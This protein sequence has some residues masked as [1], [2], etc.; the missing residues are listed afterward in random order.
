MQNASKYLQFWAKVSPDSL[1][2]ADERY[3]FTFLELDSIVRKT[4]TYL[5]NFGVKAG[6]LVA[7][8]LNSVFNYIFSITLNSMGV[9]SIVRSNKNLL[10][11]ELEPDFYISTSQPE[12][13]PPQRTVIF[14]EALVKSINKSDE[15]VTFAGFRSEDIPVVVWSTSGTTGKEKFIELNAKKL[16]E[17][18]VEPT[19]TNFF[20]N[21]HVL[22]LL[23]FGAFWSSKVAFQALLFGK[24][25]L[26]FGYPDERILEIISRF[27][28]K[29]VMGSTSQLARL[30]DDVESH[31]SDNRKVSEISTF[32]IGGEAPSIKLVERL[33]KHFDCRIF[34]NYG[35]SEVG[36]I[37]HCEVKDGT[38]PMIIRPFVDLEI[39]DSEDRVL[40]YG[41][42]GYI[43]VRSNSLPD[44]YL[45]S[46][47]DSQKALRNGF[48]YSGDL[49]L[50]DRNGNLVLSGRSANILNISGSKIHPESLEAHIA[51]IVGVSQSVALPWLNEARGVE[52]LAFA[53]V[54][55]PDFDQHLL[56]IWL[57]STFGSLGAVNIFLTGELAMNSAGKIVREEMA[58]R[59][60]GAK[61]DLRVVTSPGFSA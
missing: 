53:L 16:Y 55:T 23:P 32:I 56:E 12:L 54:T 27:S 7:L 52:E 21:D 61:P 5:E 31:L 15:R 30:L 22:N 28:V 59:I 47:Q 18:I 45:G 24:P 3:K 51:Q 17:K 11:A 35:S 13:F 33:R 48:H 29:T 37:A 40:P 38:E 57:K 25:Y 43:R 42:Q 36:G 2:V 58:A 20:P 6:D 1:A 44:R 14:N 10:P 4:A 26:S 49:G 46:D 9:K 34:N 8:N 19:I 50:L 41:V 60:K 39:V